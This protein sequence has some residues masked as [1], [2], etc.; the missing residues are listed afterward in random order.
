MKNTSLGRGLSALLKE[1]LLPIEN[2]EMVRLVDI[3]K[4][5]S[6]K[7]QP[8]K[9][10]E[11][12]KIRE[13]ADSISNSGLLQPIIVTSEIDGKYRIV[14]G[15]RRWRASKM[16]GLNDIPVII[17]NLND[18]E[19]LEIAL[20]E[21]I[22][23]EELSAIEEAQ[24]FERL[25]NEFGY[26]Q[27]KLAEILGKSRSH[28]ANLVRLN[29]LPESIKDKVNLNLL[30][31]GHDR[32]LIGHSQAELIADYIIENDLSVRQ[33]ENLVKNWSKKESIKQPNSNRFNNKI[34]QK[35]TDN[36]DLQ[37]L[38]KTLSNKLGI[39]I[40]IED[41][42]VGGKLI[43]HYNNLEQLDSILSRL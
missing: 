18:K 30:T 41:Y 7:Y 27:E 19:I 21:N 9:N 11:H 20:V 12:D 25:I 16:A 1:E 31:A 17:K 15:E 24:G 8:R 5:E 6:G 35:S 10:F 32:C 43:F 3:N 33:T 23:R 28:V 4:I 37:I 14:A 42:Y 13:L 38:A 40:S 26:T 34:S 22:Q 39:K 2:E 29:Q 36:Y